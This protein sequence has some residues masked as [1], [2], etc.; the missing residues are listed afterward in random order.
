[1]KDGSSVKK[2]YEEDL[3]NGPETPKTPAAKKEVLEFESEKSSRIA[4]QQGHGEKGKPEVKTRRGTATTNIVESGEDKDKKV[5]T[6][7]TIA[8]EA[9]RKSGKG[10]DM[11][12]EFEK[13]KKLEKGKSKDEDKEGKKDEDKKGK[14]DE[15]EGKK[16]ED[17]E[18]KKAEDK[19]GKKDEDKEG[20]KDEDKEGK[21]DGDKEGKKDEDKEGKKAENEDDKDSVKENEEPNRQKEELKGI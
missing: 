9:G 13:E 6:L 1:M 20:K 8:M 21:K 11:V 15:N 10:N 14:K 3:G 19:E 18:G 16:A 5:K 4:E 2:K 12:P 17:K 7:T